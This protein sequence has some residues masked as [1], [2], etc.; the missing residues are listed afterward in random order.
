MAPTTNDIP[1]VQQHPQSSPPA[2]ARH[3]M[4]HTA[5]KIPQSLLQQIKVPPKHQRAESLTQTY[6]EEVEESFHNMEDGDF[7]LKQT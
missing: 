6:E 5:G 4:A 3:V 7:G 2:S 1:I